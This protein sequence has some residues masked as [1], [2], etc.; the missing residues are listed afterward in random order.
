MAKTLTVEEASYK[1]TDLK[2]MNV[3]ENG[4]YLG[5]LEKIEQG[6]GVQTGEGVIEIINYFLKTDQ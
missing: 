5:T 3:F 6:D 2:G 1:G 4:D